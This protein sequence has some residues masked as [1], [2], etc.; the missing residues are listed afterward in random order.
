MD[1]FQVLQKSEKEDVAL[2]AVENGISSLSLSEYEMYYKMQDDE[3]LQ[4]DLAWISETLDK[5][6]IEDIRDLIALRKFLERVGF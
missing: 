3:K 4:S 2:E 5:L 1:N 6:H